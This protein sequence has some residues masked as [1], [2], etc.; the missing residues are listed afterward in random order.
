VQVFQAPRL[1]SVVPAID[2]FSS[3]VL[4]R[5][6]AEG[7]VGAVF[8]DENFRGIKV[9]VHRS[10]S[11]FE[12]RVWGM[13]APID[14]FGSDFPFDRRFFS[15]RVMHLREYL[16]TTMFKRPQEAWMRRLP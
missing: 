16:G 15:W 1:L 10:A 12:L 2:N 11:F 9:F 8:G 6:W 5:D 7:T 14:I 3:D 4:V 13:N